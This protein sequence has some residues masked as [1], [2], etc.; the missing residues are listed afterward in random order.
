V[1]RFPPGARFSLASRSAMAASMISSALDMDLTIINLQVTY[2]W[3]ISNV[4][5]T[6][7]KLKPIAR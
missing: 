7:L 2:N 5:G 3:M 6:I 1:V 4:T